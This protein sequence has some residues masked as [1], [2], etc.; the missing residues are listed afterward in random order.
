MVKKA[1]T[2]TITVDG[3]IVTF[4]PEVCAFSPDDPREFT[5]N[6]P[7]ETDAGGPAFVDAVGPNQ[8][9]VYLDED[10][11]DQTNDHYEF[12]PMA[13]GGGP[14]DELDDLTVDGT[15]VTAAPEMVRTD[16]DKTDFTPVGAATL[17]LTCP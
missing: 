16:Q 12:N 6:G 17:E 14:L 11:F 15:T 3:I 13:T 5:A 4:T 10:P 7:G 9:V 8:L 1:G 2:G